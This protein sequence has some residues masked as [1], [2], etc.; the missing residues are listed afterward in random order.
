MRFLLTFVFILPGLA[1]AQSSL[2]DKDSEDSHKKLR[3]RPE[4]KDTTYTNFGGVA[5]LDFSQVYL[6][7]WAGGGLNSVSGKGLLSLYL[8]YRNYKLSWDNTLDLGYGL[9]HQFDTDPNDN[10]ND[11]LTY[12]SDDK[13]DFQ[14]KIGRHAF[15]SWYYSGLLNFRTQFAEG[16]N[17]PGD[18]VI[19]SNFMAPGFAIAS[20]GLDYKPN[21]NFSLF[22]SPITSKTTFVMDEE[23]SNQGAFG[24]DTG[25]T[26][27]FEV[28]GYLKLQYTT[29]ISDNTTYTTKLDLFSNYLNN[30]Q[31]IDIS[32]ENLISV[33]IWKAIAFNL[34]THLIYDDDIESKVVNVFDSNNQIIGTRK[35]AGVQFKQVMGIGITYKF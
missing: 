20:I 5:A 28:G 26:V 25:S 8:N 1:L 31:N 35:V 21:D 15:S 30:P 22:I 2:K 9:V 3:K 10:I 6:K 34:S 23:L 19:I 29:K 11:G 32:W 33:Q 17:A 7:N 4:L 16:F 14:S 18:T 13:I 27:R 24:V 12:K